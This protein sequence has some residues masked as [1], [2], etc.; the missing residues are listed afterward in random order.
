MIYNTNVKATVKLTDFG[1]ETLRKHLGPHF[2]S[3]CQ[4]DLSGNDYTAPLWEIMH[5]FGKSLYLGCR[6][7]PFVG[8]TIDIQQERTP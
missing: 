2:D 3:V 8:N 1:M 5:I 4:Y 6:D 7:M